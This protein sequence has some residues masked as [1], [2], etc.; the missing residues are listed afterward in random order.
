MT[1]ALPNN[2]KGYLKPNNKNWGDATHVG[3]INVDNSLNYVYG[4]LK[5]KEVTNEYGKKSSVKYFALWTTQNKNVQPNKDKLNTD[6]AHTGFLSAN[7]EKNS[8]KHPHYK[9]KIQ[10]NSNEYYLACWKRTKEELINGELQTTSDFYISVSVP[11]NSYTN[12]Y[13][14]P[15]C[16]EQEDY[17]NVPF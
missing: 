7:Q 1:N 16:P 4:W 11:N 5:E 12:N 15:T 13:E 3:V 8:H 10:I 2:L 17:D 14:E 9:G 6:T